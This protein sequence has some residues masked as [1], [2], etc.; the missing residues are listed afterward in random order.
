MTETVESAG[1]APEPLIRGISDTALWAAVYRA[2]E[3]ERPDALFRD[4]YARRLAGERG[5]RIAES[6]GKRHQQ[7]WAWMARTL[8]FDRLLQGELARGADVVANLAAGL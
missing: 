1:A 8:V 7:E 6:M 4:P 3:S 2:R 5:Q